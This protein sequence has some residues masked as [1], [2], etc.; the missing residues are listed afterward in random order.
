MAK[1]QVFQKGM[2]LLLV[3]ALVA[4]MAGCATNE[5]PELKKPSQVQTQPGETAP[6]QPTEAPTEQP[7]EA[8]TEPVKTVTLEQVEVFNQ[9]GVA[10]TATG[11][12]KGLF[13]PEITFTVSN[14]SDKNI[15]VTTRSLS[16]NGYMLTMSSLY[17]EVAA[18]KK[19][20]D[21]LTL[22][23]S[24]LEQAGIETICDVAFTLHVVDPNTYEDVA[25]SGLLTLSTSAS[26]TFTQPDD[27]S[28][29][30]V[31]DKNDLRVICRGLRKDLIWDGTA[32]FYMEN[33]SGRD[34]TIYAENVSVNGYMVDVSLYSELRPG[35]KSVSGMYILDLSDL[36]IDTID[37]I[38]NLEFSLR[39]I[40]PNSWDTVDS[41]DPI[42]L[43]FG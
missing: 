43:T 29:D 18:G 2:A 8:P 13:G 6:N 12:K 33:N 37:G 16:V 10:V 28:G 32:V 31:Y 41:T 19:A 30:V 22:M 25:E 23:E 14:D 38:E 27:T 24:E 4:L 39:V 3:C 34:V 1:I 35:T 20:N 11:L 42:I 21:S 36:G 5:E 26:G 9:D 40:D 15:V 7:T 17:T